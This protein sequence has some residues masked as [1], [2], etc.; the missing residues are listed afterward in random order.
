MFAKSVILV[1][2]DTEYGAGRVFA[3]RLNIDLDEENIGLAK[4]DGDDDVLK[5]LKL[6]DAFKI[7]AV[8]ILDKDKKETYT[9]NPKIR[10]TTG[11]DFEE[12]ILKKQ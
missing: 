3:E 12:E 7:D 6:F 4:L 2:G 10:F 1:E 8:A 9:G 11:E 5:Y